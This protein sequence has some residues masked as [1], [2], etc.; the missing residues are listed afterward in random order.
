MTLH[1][2]AR[3]SRAGERV[4]AIANFRSVFASSTRQHTG[5]KVR[6]GGT[7]KPARKMRALP[8]VSPITTS[9]VKS[10]AR[11]ERQR[12]FAYGYLSN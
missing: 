5:I 8:R 9:E 12:K 2:S 10:L 6:F 1:G 3:V 4:L 7:P 11:L